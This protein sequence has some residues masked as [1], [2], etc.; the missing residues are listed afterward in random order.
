MQRAFGL[1][2]RDG[3]TVR[4]P[5]VEEKVTKQDC[6]D[7][8]VSTGV[9]PSAMYC[10]SEHANCVGCV[11]GGL[12]YWLTVMEVAP[13]VFAQRVALEEEFGHGILR[14]GGR[15]HHLLKDLHLVK[16][17]RKVNFREAIDVGPCECGD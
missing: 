13:E 1:A 12:A 11:K 14:G 15:E 16:L 9:Q 8:V 2:E 7:W 17:R 10:W 4:F 3:Y 6:A 5:I